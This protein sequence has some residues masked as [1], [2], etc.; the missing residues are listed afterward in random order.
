M[1]IQGHLLWFLH[2]Y[3]FSPVFTQIWFL[4]GDYTNMVSLRWLHINGYSE[5][6]SRCGITLIWFLAMHSK[7][8]AD[9]VDFYIN[10]TVLL[11]LKHEFHVHQ[12]IEEALCIVQKMCVVLFAKYCHVVMADDS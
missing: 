9:P 6:D 1:M 8:S 5:G 3:G 11:T 10:T 12:N 2:K 7:N 4:S